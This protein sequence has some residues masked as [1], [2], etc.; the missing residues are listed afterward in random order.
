L[1]LIDDHEA[2]QLIIS[3]T[4]FVLKDLKKL[5]QD[6]KG[7]C[8]SYTPFDTYP[9]YN[10]SMKAV[11]LLSQAWS[12]TGNEQFKSVAEEA[13]SYVMN[14]QNSDGSWYYSK[15]DIGKWIDS[16]HTGYVLD[17]ADD[18]S[19][20]SDNSSFN[21]KIIAGFNFF[22]DHFI[23]EDGFPAFYHNKLFPLDCT[24]A[25]QV[26]LTL[27]RFG[28]TLKASEVAL[29]TISNMQSEKGGFYFRKF[30]NKLRKDAFMRWSD[31]WMFVAISELLS[32]NDL[33][34]K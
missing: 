25:A 8:F 1:S 9:V 33:K 14:K 12:L 17:C 32:F 3:S 30:K 11:R 2:K 13:M 18:F 4:S 23:G 34:N 16:Y 31:A 28:K 15:S 22:E 20:L 24:A 21:N 29:F 7:F 6:E 19:E 10:A 5:D 27:C 26:I